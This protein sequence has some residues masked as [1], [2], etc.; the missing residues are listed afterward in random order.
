[1]L[2]AP[3]NVEARVILLTTKFAANDLDGART[4]LDELYLHFANW[5]PDNPY[6][7]AFPASVIAAAAPEM[8]SMLAAASFEEGVQIIVDSL[9]KEDP[10]I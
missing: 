3:D 10:N 1:M 4:V 2:L 6:H 7:E 9:A 8:R 5:V